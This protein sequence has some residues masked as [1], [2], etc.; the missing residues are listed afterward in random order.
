[1]KTS[2]RRPPA[3]DAS[4]EIMTVP[5]LAEYFVCHYATVLRLLKYHKIPGF[6][7]GSDWF[8]ARTSSGRA[9]TRPSLRLQTNLSQCD[10]KLNF[11]RMRPAVRIPFAPATRHC[12][13][14]V[15][16]EARD[17][18]VLVEHP[19]SKVREHLSL[20]VSH[21]RKLWPF[22]DDGRG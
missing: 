11:S 18:R 16:N 14:P 17:D 5:Q 15:P 1:M 13:P 9:L 19:D 22:L 10:D 3:L 8:G 12:E 6:R 21:C 4:S 20:K 2:K 7:L